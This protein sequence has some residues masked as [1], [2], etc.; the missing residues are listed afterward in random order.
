MKAFLGMGLL[1]S[2]FVKAMLK[3]GEQVQVWNRTTSRAKELEE[4]GAKCFED[5]NDAVKGADTIHLTLKD[6]ESVNDVLH[7]LSSSLT[8]GA[9][10][11]DHTTTS[12]EG[13]IQRTKNWKERGFYYQH[14]PVFMGPV[15][16]LEGTGFMMVSGDQELISKLQSELSVMT[17]KLMN[18]GPEV[19][20]AAAMKLVGN[21]FLICFVAGLRD[22]LSM[23]KALSVPTS[24][25]S[26]LLEDWNPAAMLQ[27]RLKRMTSGDYSQPSWELNM[28]RKDAGLFMEAS[29]NKTE[30]AI[31]PSVAALMDEWIE[32]G[33]GNNDWTVIAKDVI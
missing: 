6:D 29:E 20:K 10:I 17:G 11:I 24:D 19:G 28:A 33:Y 13:A 32:K 7:V 26:S 5:I 23:A 15:N 21:T 22:T 2:N 3:K 4:F 12:K 27:A 16:A 8:P 31:I 30:L 14:A 18:F 9:I 25:L 1:G